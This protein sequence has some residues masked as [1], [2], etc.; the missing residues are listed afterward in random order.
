MPK[1]NA[2]RRAMTQVF[3]PTVDLI[4]APDQRALVA[5][6]ERAVV[7]F[8]RGILSNDPVLRRAFYEVD[9]WVCGRPTGA[10]CSFE[11]V[12]EKLCLDA[13]YL[14]DGLRKLKERA[15]ATHVDEPRRATGR[16]GENQ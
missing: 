1:R 16:G 9:R 5:L 11:W 7:T 15:Y 2:R 3:L 13:R 12:C 10:G 8:R 4:V 6:L 14:R